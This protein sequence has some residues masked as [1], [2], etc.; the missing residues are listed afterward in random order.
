MTKNIFEKYKKKIYISLL[1]RRKFSNE[2]QRR[3]ALVDYFL[4]DHNSTLAILETILSINNMTCL[5]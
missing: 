1:N 2:F 3:V 4:G 5:K